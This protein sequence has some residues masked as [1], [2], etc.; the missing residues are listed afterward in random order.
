MEGST[1]SGASLVVVLG[2]ARLPLGVPVLLEV[3][4]EVAE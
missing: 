2:V 1:P 3:L 4:V